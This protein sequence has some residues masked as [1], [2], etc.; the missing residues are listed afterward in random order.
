MDGTAPQ[1]I[2]TALRGPVITVEDA[3][4]DEAREAYNTMIDR[5][6]AAVVR[7]G[8]AGDVRDG[9]TIDLSP[10]SGGTSKSIARARSASAAL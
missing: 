6:P 8:D 10:M 5:R 7:S 3:A 2:R 4:Y 1:G 9:V